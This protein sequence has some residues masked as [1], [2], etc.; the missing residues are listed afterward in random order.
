MR[1]TQN[2]FEINNDAIG[3]IPNRSEKHAG[4]I[5]AVFQH[6]SSIIPHYLRLGRYVINW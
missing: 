4:I 3:E 2:I 6:Y 1:Q 5:Q